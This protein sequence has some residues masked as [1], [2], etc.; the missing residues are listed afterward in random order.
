MLYLLAMDLLWKRCL[1]Q[2]RG[3]SVDHDTLL[4]PPGSADVFFPTNF[5]AAK[6]LW[7]S[8]MDVPEASKRRCRVDIQP[9]ATFMTTYAD[10]NRTKTMTAYNPLLDDFTNTSFLIADTS[11]KDFV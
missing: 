2:E 1:V 7:M 4:V 9:S 3:G 11:A 6:Q 10:T 8:C 5:E